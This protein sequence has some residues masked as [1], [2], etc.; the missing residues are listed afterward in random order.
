MPLRRPRRAARF[1]KF[2]GTEIV[3]RTLMV[4]CPRKPSVFRTGR[5]HFAAHLPDERRSSRKSGTY[6][7]ELDVRHARFRC[8]FP[9]NG[10]TAA[11]PCESDRNKRGATRTKELENKKPRVSGGLSQYKWMALVAAD[12]LHDVRH[13]ARFIQSAAH[14]LQHHLHVLGLRLERL[15]ADHLHD[16][17]AAVLQLLQDLRHGLGG[18]RL[19]V[20]HQDDAFAV[21]LELRHH[22][23]HDLLG[24]AH[25]EVERIEVGRED[26]D[27]SLA[28]ILYELGW[29][30]QRREAEEG[31]NRLVFS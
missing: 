20:M 29:M 27:G 24:L 1:P 10:Q 21:F 19:E 25:F 6:E 28:E 11:F 4:L 22:R 8:A 17:V 14:L 23:L 12:G 18:R 16:L 7:L 15:C 26:A 13:R 3:P 30:P 5:G 31:R 2:F 9:M